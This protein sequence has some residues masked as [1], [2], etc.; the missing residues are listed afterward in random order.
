MRK[1]AQFGLSL[2]LIAIL[3]TGMAAQDDKSKEKRKK[4]APELLPDSTLVYVQID[5][6]N[7]LKRKFSE[8]TFG[9]M[10]KDEKMRPFVEG[11]M[12]VAKDSYEDV[13][14]QVAGQELS[15]LFNVPQGEICFGLVGMKR[16]EPVPIFFIDVDPESDT[17]KKLIERG[18][19]LAEEDG[20]TID[21]EDV[22]GIKFHTVK[23]ND[24][25]EE[26]IYFEHQGTYVF[27]M[28]KDILQF[29]WMNWQDKYEG[30]QKTLAEHRK[31]ITIMNRCRGTKKAPP[32]FTFYVDP[33]EIYKAYTKGNATARLAL[34]FLPTLGLDGLLAVGGSV[35]YNEQGYD[36]IFHGH[37]LLAS[38]RS[39]IFKMIA[40]KPGINDP[41]PWV[42]RDCIS[43]MTTHWN[44]KVLFSELTKIVDAFSEDGAFE[45]MIGKNIN[46]RLDIDFEEDVIK[47][48]DGRLTLVTW[49]EPPSRINSQA[50][51][52]SFKI[53]DMEKF[54][55][56][57][58]KVL[59]FIEKSD[60]GAIEEIRYKGQSYWTGSEERRK[61]R[62]ERV[63]EWRERQRREQGRE[64]DEDRVRLEV[65]RQDPA[66]MIIDDYLIVSD[67][68][69]FLKHII[70][71]NRKEKKA[72]ADDEDY[73]KIIKE[74]EKLL[75]TQLPSMT[76]F[77][78][79]S[80]QIRT[81]FEA[82]KSDNTKALMERGSEGN[83]YVKKLRDAFEDSPLPDFEH[84]KKYFPPAGGFVVS[85]DSGFHFMA[86]SLKP[87]L[88]EDNKKSADRK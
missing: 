30:K 23:G 52:V 83:K 86:F 44:A 82:A 63:R 29:V 45:G 87:D 8:S 54:S 9:K 74:M 43:Y 36:S 62:E 32:E 51:A 71:V 77:N 1:T 65:R 4:K 66:F 81:F 19:E 12:D 13:K 27:C 11:M 17:H 41:E 7:E 26:V 35:I 57:V 22:E 14:E 25:D 80:E 42:P 58:E 37:I 59:D 85:D 24:D 48:L 2:V 84:V 88:E 75:S 78:R 53:K 40:L 68:K 3:A 20:A 10:I 21:S 6:I 72:L 56:V 46:E 47:S 16:G 73:K 69:E 39:G 70:E 28:D 50:T 60:E 31:F 67:S 18:K 38:P 15:D 79:P 61:Q 64:D 76:F 5:D 34:A 33:I 49:S 55:K